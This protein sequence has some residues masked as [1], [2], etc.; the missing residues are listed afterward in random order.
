M[1]YPEKIILT[2]KQHVTIGPREFG[3]EGLVAIESIGPFNP[4]IQAC[5]PIITIHDSVIDA[6]KGIGHHPHRHNE[7]LFYLEKGTF[8]HDDAKNNISGHIPEGGMARFTE[9]QHGML[10][11]EWNNGEIG[12]AH[13]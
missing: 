13:V 2:P 1:A 8:D 3:T 11:K 6:G 4:V 10:H 5:G 7:R 12:R 9:G